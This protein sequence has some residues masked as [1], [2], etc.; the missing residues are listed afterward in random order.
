MMKSPIHISAALAVLVSGLVVSACNGP[1][2]SFSPAGDLGK[3][4]HGS[5]PFM[6]SSPTPSPIPF[7]FL[8][9]D[10]PNSLKNQVNGINQLGKLVGSYG[11]G[12]SSNTYLSF[13]VQPPYTKFRDFSDPGAQGT[14][15]TSL[16][17]N[18]IDAG[19]V[20]QPG[21]LS[22]TWAFLRIS[23]IYTL[24]DSPSEGSGYNAVTEIWGLNDK[25]AA[26][27]FYV[28]SSGV[29][30]PFELD[31]KTLKFTDVTPPGATSGVATGINGKAEIVGWDATPSK[32][33]RGFFDQAGTYYPFSAPGAQATYPMSINLQDQVVGYYAD[34]TGA[35][36]GFVM[37]NPSWGGGKQIWQTIDE[38]NAA[39]GTW[40]TGIN[41]HDQICG[42][43]VDAS[44][45][46][47]GFVADP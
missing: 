25:G 1:S 30:V 5:K 9:V 45:V 24:V 10:D 28:N 27:G 21:N 20:I 3:R 43:Y 39:A 40:V 17:S 31:I 2:T 36:H 41:M 19:Y 46:Q 34:G 42:Y 23:G 37:T 13:T 15:A 18:K 32:P 6:A 14:V 35:M 44:G 12:Q 38:P 7:S 26:V 33:I 16:S 11:G 8:T 29:Q 47:H 22:G 4:S